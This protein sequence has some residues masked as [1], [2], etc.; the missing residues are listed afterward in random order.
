MTEGP[1][2][3]Q[4]VEAQQ[5]VFVDPTGRRARVLRVL[6]W[7][8]SGALALSLA[9]LVVALVAPPSLTRVLVPGLELPGAAAPRL[10]PGG[11]GRVGRP[12]SVLRTPT[13]TPSA[14][15]SVPSSRPAA[16][17]TPVGPVTTRTPS[18][19]AR[20]TPSRTPSPSPTPTQGNRPT[21]PPGQDPSA[22]PGG[23]KPTDKP[24]GRPSSR[25]TGKP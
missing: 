15:A 8:L 19:T 6:A 14:S 21:T 2:E 24:T 5:H 3:G 16:S 25:P 9:L 22:T 20:P 1:E 7:V 10:D 4:V 17:A 23:G 13:P 11:Q 18:P 12:A